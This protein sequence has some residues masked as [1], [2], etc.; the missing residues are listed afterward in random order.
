MAFINYNYYWYKLEDGGGHLAICMIYEI[1]MKKKK[2]KL[3][4]FLWVLNLLVSTKYFAIV[5]HFQTHKLELC[6]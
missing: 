3:G 4:V 6:K 5:P 1:R 2:W